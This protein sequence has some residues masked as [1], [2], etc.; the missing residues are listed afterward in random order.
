MIRDGLERLQILERLRATI[1]P[2]PGSAIAR[3]SALESANYMRNQLLRDAD[4]AG[5]A[6]GVEIRTPYVDIELLRKIAPALPGLRHADKKSML[7]NAVSVRLPTSVTQPKKLGFVVPIEHWA[8]EQKPSGKTRMGM[9]SRD[10]ALSVM[11]DY[12]ASPPAGIGR[13][14]AQ[15]ADRPDQQSLTSTEEEVVPT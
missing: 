4:W 13:G 3:V 2:D 15:Q 14:T 9:T 8:S 1:T 6:H 5:M 10:W 7:A 12:V 11:S